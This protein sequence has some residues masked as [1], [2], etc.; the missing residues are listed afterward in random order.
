MINKLD[1]AL[2]F[3]Q[4]ALNLRAARQELLASNI[5]NADTPN[6]KAKDVNFATAL[7]NALAGTSPALP[8]AQT[9]PMHL[10]G[11]TGQ[12]IMGTPVMYRVPAQ[13]SADGNTVDMD[14]E[15]TQFTDNALR[16]EAGVSFVSDE[17][18]DIQAAIQS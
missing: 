1:E 12:A 14:V 13:P 9:S 8:P 4:T 5:A 15:R 6:Y 3:Q 7:Q 17:L 11:N 2:R 10:Q 18:K 16:Y